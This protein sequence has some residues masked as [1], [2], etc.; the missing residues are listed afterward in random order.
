MRYLVSTL[1]VLSLVI[2]SC[3]SNQNTTKVN[4]KD[5][6][7]ITDLQPEISLANYLR[8]FSGIMVKGTGD[9]AL[10]LVRSGG[11]S[12]TGTSEPLFLINGNQFNGSFNELSKSIAVDQIKSVTVYKDAS[13]TAFY[14]IRGANGVIDIKLK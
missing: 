8:R 2:T 1:L 3:S 14:G 10:V 11:N 13:D 5:K 12:L 6:N 9:D 7:T 4:S